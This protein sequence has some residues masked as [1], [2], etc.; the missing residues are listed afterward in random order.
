LVTDTL[1]LREDGT[2]QQVYEN[3]L[4]NYYYT[5]PWNRW[6]VEYRPSGGLYLHL[7][8]MHYCLN[9]DAVCRGKGGGG[10]GPYYDVC[11]DRSIR[12]MG[13]EVILAVA[14]TEGFR[15]PG[16]ESVPRGIILVHMRSGSDVPD[17]FFILRE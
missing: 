7:E 14:G 3:N 6:Y 9:G 8:W 15:Y 4:A 12:D 13:D 2:Y 11:E 5:G 1:I 17:N 10:Y 16:I